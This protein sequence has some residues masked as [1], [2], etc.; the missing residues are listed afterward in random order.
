MLILFKV[1]QL[2]TLDE[3]AVAHVLNRT[4]IYQK[5]AGTRDFIEGLVG[6]GGQLVVMNSLSF[7]MPRNAQGF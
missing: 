2:H 3:K 7:L 4:D 6:R 1:N 5:T